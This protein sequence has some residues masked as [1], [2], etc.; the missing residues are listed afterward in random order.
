MLRA[1]PL[2]GGAP[3]QLTLLRADDEA[4]RSKAE[5]QVTLASEATAAGCSHVLPLLRVVRPPSHAHI[6]CV[7][8]HLGGGD[9]FDRLSRAG[10]SSALGSACGGGRRGSGC[11]VWNLLRTG[12][13]VGP[14]PRDIFLVEASTYMYSDS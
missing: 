7:S 1:A 9:L 11:A 3:V 5:R 10:L 2:E 4:W 12:V 14:Q 13:A 8:P 6:V